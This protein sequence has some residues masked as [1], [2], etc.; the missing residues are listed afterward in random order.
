M[1]S[2]NMASIV[3]LANGTAVS[4]CLTTTTIYR[5][6]QELP[7]KFTPMPYTQRYKIKRVI[8][9]TLRSVTTTSTRPLD[10]QLLENRR[11][12]QVQVIRNG[13]RWRCCCYL[14]IKLILL[15]SL[16]LWLWFIFHCIYVVVIIIIIISVL[17]Y[18]YFYY[19]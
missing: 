4:S 11:S 8:V 15:L 5:L 17:F 6:L 16:L 3:A 2:Y 18:Y 9:I 7:D 12:S 19:K 14:I 13:C 10:I 1:F